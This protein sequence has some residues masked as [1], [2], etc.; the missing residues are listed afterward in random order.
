[1]TLECELSKPDIPVKWLKDGE[2]ITPA[3]NITIVTDGYLQ[4]LLIADASISD[5]AIYTC[6]CGNVSTQATLKVEGKGQGQFLSFRL[7]G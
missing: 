5:S 6:V 7:A 3:D 2:E 4:Q 1:M